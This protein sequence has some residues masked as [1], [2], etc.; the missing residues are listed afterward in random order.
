M[1]QALSNTVPVRARAQTP[2][3]RR[4]DGVT[5]RFRF[6]RF[7]QLQLTSRLQTLTNAMPTPPCTYVSAKDMAPFCSGGA[8]SYRPLFDAAVVSNR[9]T[10]LDKPSRVLSKI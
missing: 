5:L 4:T 9:C 6:L 1:I 7:T 10:P 8:R 2:A 3:R